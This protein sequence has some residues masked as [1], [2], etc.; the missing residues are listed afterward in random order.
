MNYNILLYLLS[1]LL[2]LILLGQNPKFINTLN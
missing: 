2:D 1:I